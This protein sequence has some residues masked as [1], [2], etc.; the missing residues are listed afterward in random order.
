MP[1][2]LD[3][4]PYTKFLQTIP[5]GKQGLIKVDTTE[6]QMHKHAFLV[7]ASY[8][9]CRVIV[10][11]TDMEDGTSQLRIRTFSPRQRVLIAEE[12]ATASEIK[13][14][15]QRQQAKSSTKQW[16]RLFARIK[17]IL[18]LPTD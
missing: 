17:R 8:E 16:R 4:T 15:L 9:N 1:E 2:R 11:V 13:E 10:G 7:A 12:L 18:R 3:L 14:E 5:P 6:A